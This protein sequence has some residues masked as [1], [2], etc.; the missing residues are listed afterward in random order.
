MENPR[1]AA[2]LE[3]AN[4]VQIERMPLSQLVPAAYNPRKDLQPGELEYEKLKRSIEEFGLVEPLVYNR[5][6]G[7]LVGGHQRLKVLQASGATENEVSVVDLDEDRERALNI[8]L[9][10][11]S[12]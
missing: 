3:G 5:R 10:S 7:R 11:I 2:Y 1:G 12:P 9:T 6:T 4:D 8:A